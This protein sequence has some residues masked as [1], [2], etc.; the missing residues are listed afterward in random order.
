MVSFRSDFWEA[1]VISCSYGM[2]DPLAPL[3]PPSCRGVVLTKTEVLNDGGS[4]SEGNSGG[5]LNP[6][7]AIF[8]AHNRMNLK[9]TP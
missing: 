2:G 3:I 9:E 7:R 8:R 4:E 1:F 6:G 5:V